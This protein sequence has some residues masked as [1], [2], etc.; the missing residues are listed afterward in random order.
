M[1]LLGARSL[2]MV[3]AVSPGVLLHAEIFVVLAVQEDELYDLQFGNSFQKQ[4]VDPNN[5]EFVERD[6]FALEVANMDE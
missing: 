4:A 1:A 3:H 5:R 2:L 6:D